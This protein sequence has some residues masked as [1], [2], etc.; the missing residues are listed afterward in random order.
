ML[1]IR[2]LLFAVLILT[3]LTATSVSVAE[4]RDTFYIAPSQV[5]LSHV[6]QPP[7]AAN[8]QTQK[9]DLI[10]V[11]TLQKTRTEAQIKSARADNTLTIFAFVRD[12]LGP[13]FNK[14][15]LK[16]TAPF[17]DR[18][19]TDQIESCLEVKNHFNRQRP[20]I[21][22]PE[23][24]PIVQQPPNTSYPSGH[25]TTGYVYATI[26]SMMVPDKAPAL[27]DRA[28]VYGRNR[29]IAGVHFPTDVEA[30]RISAAVIV[31][32]MIQQP[33]FMRD[34]ERAKKELRQ[35]LELE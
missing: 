13:N 21:I 32:T 34:F 20:F 9:D 17:F 8:S 30:G 7:P 3:M 6:I 28:A 16:I 25:T 4:A 1:D 11:Q 15:K 26:L 18:V 33:L 2:K 24:K 35:V 12:V 5:A 22:D 29:I 14:E 19:F 23:I 27:F 10:A 31:N